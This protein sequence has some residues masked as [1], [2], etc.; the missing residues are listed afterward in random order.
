MSAR[1][2]S[3]S[4]ACAWHHSHRPRRP[5]ARRLSPRRDAARRARAAAP[6]G[7]VR[8]IGSCGALARR[9]PRLQR[10]RARPTRRALARGA[11]DRDR[12]DADRRRT[13]IVRRDDALAALRLDAAGVGSPARRSRRVRSPARPPARGCG[14]AGRTRRPGGL[15]SPEHR[16][17][18]AVLG[19]L[20]E[21]SA[22]R[23][24]TA[25]A[26][27]APWR[28]ARRRGRSQRSRRG[29]CAAR[30]TAGDAPEPAASSRRGDG[31]SSVACTRGGA[32]I[33]RL[34]VA[35]SAGDPSRAPSARAAGVPAP[36]C[37][38]VRAAER[39]GRSPGRGTRARRC[40]AQPRRRP[41]A[42]VPPGPRR[43]QQAVAQV[44]L[45]LGR[46]VPLPRRPGR[47][48]SERSRPKSLRNSVVVR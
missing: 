32:P 7:L 1:P 12:D 10:D 37:P 43:P 23:L 48:S 22:S 28:V 17:A 9:L 24:T 20:A 6:S 47:S 26:I 4:T 15:P 18:A 45:L 3:A 16:R 31:S 42:T 44:G 33:R 27:A 35:I 21:S 29:C 39:R 36:A 2:R 13:S 46:R 40:A 41:R 5:G 11:A 14:V 19:G 38:L 30:P 8:A 34:A 25:A